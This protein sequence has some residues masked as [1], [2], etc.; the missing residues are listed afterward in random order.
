M[1]HGTTYPYSR[2]TLCKRP[3]GA[4]VQGDLIMCSANQVETQSRDISVIEEGLETVVN[5]VI[6]LPAAIQPQAVAE[7]QLRCE[8]GV[9]ALNW[10]PN[11]K[12]A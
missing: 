9:C 5:N 8:N 2:L 4:Y 10:K 3:H 1:K 7:P 11:K 6:E 12:A